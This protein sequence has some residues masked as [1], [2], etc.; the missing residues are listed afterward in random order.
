MGSDDGWVAQVRD[1]A[2]RAGEPVWPLP[3]PPEY[4]KLLDSEVADLRNVGTAELRRRAHCGLVPQ[5]VR[6]RRTAWAHLDIAGPA[7]AGSDDAYITKGGTGFATRTLIELAAT[8][9]PPIA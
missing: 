9:R 6:R 4:R 8:F 7:R 2:D 1:A 5:G 3:L